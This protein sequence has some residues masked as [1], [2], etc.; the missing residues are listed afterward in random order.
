MIEVVGIR[1][2]KA[3]KMY[4]FDPDGLK[5][6][7]DQYAIVETARGVE[8]GMVIKGNS[9]VA[10][11][12]I[13]PP[14]K[15][16]LRAATEEDAKTM[17]AN[18]KKEEEAF[19]ICLQK[20]ARLGL[21]MKLVDVEITFDKNKLIFYFTSDG[22]VDFR[23]LVKEL[24]AVFRMRIELRQIG[25][26]D[27]AKMLNGIGICGR[28]LCCATFLGDFQPVSIKMAKEQNLSLNPTKISGICGRLM[29]CLKYEEE[30]YEE[31]NR[32][33]PY[34]GDI[35]STPDGTGEILATNVL[36]QQVKAAVRKTENDAPTIAFY[37]VDEIKV[38]KSKKKRKHEPVPEEL[39]AYED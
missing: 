3:G 37:H 26:R 36:M 7:R 18:A 19:R 21:D 11:D 35:I 34:V 38:I 33:L 30:V 9:M 12:S 24:A 14:L 1:F 29:C 28:A 25:V 17:E 22:R 15:K 13:V 4:Y 5:L 2:K 6:E 8:Y 20:I 27:E 10:E 23:E 32:K 39:K 16:V 31:L